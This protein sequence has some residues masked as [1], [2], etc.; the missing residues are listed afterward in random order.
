[1]QALKLTCIKLLGIVYLH[2]DFDTCLVPK[3]PKKE[4]EGELKNGGRPFFALKQP[5]KWD[6]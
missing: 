6:W 1:M 2:W 3:K 4:V 5:C